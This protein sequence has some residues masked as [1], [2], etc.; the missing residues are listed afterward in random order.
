MGVDILPR[1]EQTGVLDWPVNALHVHNGV[2]QIDGLADPGVYA[3][4]KIR[5]S[6][7]AKI[8][9]FVLYNTRHCY[10]ADRT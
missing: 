8:L 9:S 2:P 1:I 5:L 7:M 6:E 4:A 10:G 3:M